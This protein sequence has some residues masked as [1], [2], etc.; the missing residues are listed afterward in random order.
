MNHYSVIALWTTD[1]HSPSQNSLELI[2]P[3]SSRNMGDVGTSYTYPYMTSFMYP[4]DPAAPIFQE[5]SGKFQSSASKCKGLKITPRSSQPPP[6]SQHRPPKSHPQEATVKPKRRRASADQLAILNG[7]YA[8]TAFPSTE[9]RMEL[10][11]RL[12]MSPR[13]VQIWWAHSQEHQRIN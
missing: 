6:T 13:Q 12:G 5:N 10:A 4:S 1:N 11:T 7:V 8:Q 3:Q 9:W 2:H